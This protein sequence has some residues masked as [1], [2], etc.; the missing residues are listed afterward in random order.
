MEK[1]M[2]KN[3]N[4][5]D[6]QDAKRIESYLGLEIY[7]MEQKKQNMIP[8]Q[9][10]C[11]ILQDNYKRIFAGELESNPILCLKEITEE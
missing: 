1:E 7:P 8:E 11:K 9:L 5:E 2:I 6:G 3:A 4:G 10:I